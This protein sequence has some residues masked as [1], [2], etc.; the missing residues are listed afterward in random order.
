MNYAWD[1]PSFADKQLLLKIESK[2]FVLDVLEIGK[3]S[4]FKVKSVAGESSYLDLEVKAQG[5]AVLI[6][7]KDR[8][9]PPEAL[10]D[11]GSG[12]QVRIYPELLY[13]DTSSLAEFRVCRSIPECDPYQTP[14][15]GDFPGWA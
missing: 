7:L 12:E 9:A 2:E 6:L 4:H 3:K 5:P 13:N 8:F 1:Q 11:A 15:C 14:P 10:P